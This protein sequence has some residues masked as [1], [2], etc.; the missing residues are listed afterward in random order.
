ME[1]REFHPYDLQALNL[2]Y[3]Q[4]AFAPSM[5]VEHG[6]ALKS[7]GDDNFTVVV[8][9]KPIACIGLVEH[10]PKRRYVWAYLVEGIGKRDMV[11]LRQAI[12]QWLRYHGAGRI[13]TAIDPAF[14]KSVG[15]AESLGFEREGVLRHW[16]PD[17]SDWIMYSRIDRG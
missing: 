7:G 11:R 10:W 15:W 6:I 2:Q 5:T 17:G 9:G 14:A 12:A 13:E 1:I 16:T 8:D 4:A 3:L